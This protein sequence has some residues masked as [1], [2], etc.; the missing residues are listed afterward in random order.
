M[1]NLEGGSQG[2]EDPEKSSSTADGAAKPRQK[3]LTVHDET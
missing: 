1:Q 3:C 2:G